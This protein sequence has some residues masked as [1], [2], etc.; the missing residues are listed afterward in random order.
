MNRLSSF[1][2]QRNAWAFNDL[3]LVEGVNHMVATHICY[4]V[5]Y[6][7]NPVYVINELK[8]GRLL[9]FTGSID[10]LHKR[11]YPKKIIS[12][13]L[14]E[15]KV[16]GFSDYAKMDK[17]DLLIDNQIDEEAKPERREPHNHVV[18]ATVTV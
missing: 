14:I 8:T 6:G 11:L 3:K 13:V 5:K 12:K 1:S 2:M 7:P 17:R 15:S 16:E 4:A 9:K 10:S 18:S